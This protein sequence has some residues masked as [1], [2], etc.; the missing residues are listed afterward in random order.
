MLGRR[1]FLKTTALATL[2]A[3]WP[4]PLGAATAPAPLP[5][6]RIGDVFIVNGWIL[7]ARDLDALGLH[8]T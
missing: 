3:A 2:A 6:R 4:P 7:T 5:V 1:S 8:D